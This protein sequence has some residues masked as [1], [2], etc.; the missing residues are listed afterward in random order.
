MLLQAWE[1]NKIPNVGKPVL[2]Y[3]KYKNLQVETTNILDKNIESWGSEEQALHAFFEEFKN[4]L[5]NN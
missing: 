5:N 2:R 1:S 3:E 4:I